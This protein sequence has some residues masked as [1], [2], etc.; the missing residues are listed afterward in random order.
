MTAFFYLGCI[1]I[2]WGAT[3]LVKSVRKRGIRRYK[4]DNLSLAEG[5]FFSIGGV[6]LVVLEVLEL[7]FPA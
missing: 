5:L 4:R 7:I 1:A 3:I 6:V 2:V